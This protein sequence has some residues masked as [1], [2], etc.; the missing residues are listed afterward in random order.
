MRIKRRRMVVVI[1]AIAL[2]GITFIL[3]YE[4]ILLAVGDFLVIQDKVHPADVIHVISGPDYRTDYAIH[5]YKKGYAKQIFFTGGWCPTIQANHGTHA[6]SRAM[7]QRL[8]S[9]AIS[10]DNSRV[11]STYSEAVRLK[12]FIDQSSVPIHSVIVVSDPHHMRRARWAYRR[13]LGDNIS[14]QMAPV[15]FKQSPYKRRWWTDKLSRLM[16]RNEYLKFVYY[17]ARYQLSSGSL[18]KW[19]ASLD[20]G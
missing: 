16:V 14:L 7:E 1:A 15:P 9:Q 17:I 2:L 19:L 20:R 18:R 10:I 5:L 12:V 11:T 6:L 4:P 3:N 13:V 8:P